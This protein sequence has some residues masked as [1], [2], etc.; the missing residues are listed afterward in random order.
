MKGMTKRNIVIATNCLE[1][2]RTSSLLG[3]IFDLPYTYQIPDAVFKKG[4]SELSEEQRT[5]VLRQGLRLID[6]L[7]NLMQRAPRIT[8]SNAKLTIY[9]AMGCSLAKL[10]ASKSTERN[11]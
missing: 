3:S 8:Q 2:V 5:M 6:L 11:G 4:L 9:D 7:G 10:A 1:D